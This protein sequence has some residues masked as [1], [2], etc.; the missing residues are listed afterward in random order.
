[1]SWIPDRYSGNAKKALNRSGFLF[2]NDI[3]KF[4]LGNKA[5]NLGDL[6]RFYFLNLV[7]E[8]VAKE[9]L[10]GDVAE[11]GVYKGNTATLFAD[12]AR[13]KGK[14]AY[15]FDTFTGFSKIDIRGLDSEKELEFRDTSLEKVKQF[16][17]TESVRYV[18]GYFPDSTATIP[19]NLRFCAVHLDCDLY[20]PMKAGLEYFYPRLVSGGFMIMHDY[21]SLYWDGAES[22]VDEF[23]SDKAERV[24][25]VPDKSGTA[26][27]RKL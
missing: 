22:A 12:F 7:L 9:Q 19:N 8:Q 11:L 18:A 1:M 13:A 26:V 6:A 10:T 4:I 27:F 16:V 2:A 24:T 21:S 17:G 15:L 3:K 20:S 23:L 14:T 25:P 5:N